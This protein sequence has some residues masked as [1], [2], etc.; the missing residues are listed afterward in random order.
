MIKLAGDTSHVRYRGIVSDLDE[1]RVLVQVEAD[2]GE[3]WWPMVQWAITLEVPP[4]S[5]VRQRG[6]ARRHAV[7]ETGFE[8][9]WLTPE[10]T[11]PRQ[12]SGRQTLPLEPSNWL[13]IA[14][15]MRQYRELL[16]TRWGQFDQIFRSGLRSAV[17]EGAFGGWTASRETVAKAAGVTRSRLDQI[18]AVEGEVSPASSIG[19]AAVQAKKAAAKTATSEPKK[20]TA[21]KATTPAAKKAPTKTKPTNK[22]AGPHKRS[23]GGHGDDA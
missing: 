23:K 4:D 8:Q 16:L 11:W 10:G 21:P 1:N 2:V 12:H 19:A 14:A 17:N 20:T 13:A 22:P 9:G 15:G 18:L 5:T 6:A 3:G 7:Q